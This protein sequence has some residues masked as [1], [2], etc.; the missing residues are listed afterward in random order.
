MKQIRSGVFETNS[1][2]VHSIT[3]CMQSEY[4]AWQ[5]GE[6]YLNDNRWIHSS[7]AYTKKQFVTKEEAIDILNKRDYGSY[8]DLTTLEPEELE[9]YLKDED[10]YTYENYHWDYYEG[11]TNSYTTPNGD[12]VVSFGYYGHD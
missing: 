8:S 3:M 12:T 1:S 6:V 9:D 4:D 10:F 7:S 2:S 11:F 5:N